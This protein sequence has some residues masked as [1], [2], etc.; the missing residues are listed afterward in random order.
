MLAVHWASLCQHDVEQGGS[1]WA[2]AQGFSLGSLPT[3]PQFY[4]LVIMA[5]RG[6]LEQSYIMITLPLLS[7]RKGL[8]LL[9]LEDTIE[10]MTR[11][12]WWL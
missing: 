10:P 7:Y 1:A 11:D 8:A 9:T 6:F 3:W 2:A 12:C 5:L 4:F